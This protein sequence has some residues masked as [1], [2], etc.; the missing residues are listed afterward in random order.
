MIFSEKKKNKIKMFTNRVTFATF[1][2]I[3]ISVQLTPL[4]T[5]QF[6]GHCQACFKALTQ[7]PSK[8]SIPTLGRALVV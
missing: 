7:V 6:L 3:S 2:T 8:H 1:H 4:S 5:Y